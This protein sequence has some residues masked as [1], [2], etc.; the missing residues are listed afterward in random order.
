MNYQIIA[1]DFDGTL[2]YSNWP[3]LGEPNIPLIEYLKFQK[4]Q[5]NKL[6]LWT[7]RAGAALDL[8]VNWCI[9]H[10]LSFDAVNDN[11]PEIIELYGN[12]SR[13]ITCDYYI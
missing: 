2:C 12:N 1:V 3:G 9:E 13:K 5:G 11:L 10:E 8:A 7:C 4:K 6:I